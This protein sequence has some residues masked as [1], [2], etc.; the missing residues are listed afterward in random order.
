ME[1]TR[2]L[3]GSHVD[4]CTLWSLQESTIVLCAVAVA[5]AETEPEKASLPVCV[6]EQSVELGPD[7]F[8][9]SPI[10]GLSPHTP[11]SDVIGCPVHCTLGIDE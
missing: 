9:S 8:S 6:V 5:K 2:V 4:T 3:E 7:V 1:I 10:V 11:P